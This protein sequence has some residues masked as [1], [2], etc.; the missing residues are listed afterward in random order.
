MCVIY[1]YMWDI[2]I[3]VIYIMYIYTYT[4][5]GISTHKQMSV[6]YCF[7]NCFWAQIVTKGSESYFN[8]FIISFQQN[9]FKNWVLQ[10]SLKWFPLGLTFV[11][12]IAYIIA[13]CFPVF[14]KVL[15]ILIDFWKYDNR[16]TQQSLF[17]RWLPIA[18]FFEF[19][20]FLRV[21]SI[22]IMLYCTCSVKQWFAW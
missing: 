12:L 3:Y 20:I 18:T 6:S 2:Y 1:I 4:L 10:R 16:Q 7:W 11:S 19:D 13:N 14:L 17:P 22:D 5:T 21:N 9:Y 8:L 15:A